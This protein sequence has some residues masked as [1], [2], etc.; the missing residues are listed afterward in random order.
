VNT[1]NV[2]PMPS[3]SNSVFSRL[4]EHR[5]LVAPTAWDPVLQLLQGNCAPRLQ[6][7][8]G[9]DSCDAALL[10]L[11]QNLLQAAGRQK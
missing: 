2:N 7:S 9:A 4:C 6:L 1:G 3:H 10:P 11:N 8:V 5:P